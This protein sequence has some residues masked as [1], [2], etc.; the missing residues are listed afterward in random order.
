MASC[1]QKIPSGNESRARKEKMMKWVFETLAKDRDWIIGWIL[2]YIINH[3]ILSIYKNTNIVIYELNSGIKSY[4]LPS[5]TNTF[6]KSKIETL[7]KASVF[8]DIVLLSLMLTFNI[9]HTFFLCFCCWL[10]VGKC[11]LVGYLTQYSLDVLC[12]LRFKI[13]LLQENIL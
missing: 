7:P 5:K 12:V 10:W 9:L 13:N 8:N 2:Q 11:L 1:L 6:S 4:I 3:R